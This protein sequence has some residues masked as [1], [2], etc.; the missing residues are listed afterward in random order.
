M[1][2]T[3]TI[4]GNVTRDPEIR[5]MNDGSPYTRFGLAETYRKKNKDEVTSFYDVVV[6]YSTATNV[7]D[8][9]KK[10][11]RV[12]ITGRQEVRDFERKDG[13]KGTVIEIVADEVSASLRFATVSITKND[14]EPAMAGAS[15][16]G[17]ANSAGY[18]EF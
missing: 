7:A 15:N 5:F 2:S 1:P 14:R 18:E 16:F 9:I 8:S 6:F 3:V 10:G 13:T 11:H 17:S 12:T 4:T